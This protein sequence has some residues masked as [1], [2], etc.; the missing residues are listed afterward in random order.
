MKRRAAHGL[1]VGSLGDVVER[2]SALRLNV[3]AY[4]AEAK[5]ELGLEYE[6]RRYDKGTIREV[7]IIKRT[8][9]VNPRRGMSLSWG[10][11]HRHRPPGMARGILHMP[12]RTEAE[13]RGRV[14]DEGIRVGEMS[15]HR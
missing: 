13:T 5:H 7:T 15:M 4:S 9:R 12:H 14:R 11:W 3:S 10:R 2:L 1:V 6:E 8:H